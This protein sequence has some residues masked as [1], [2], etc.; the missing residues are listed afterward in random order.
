M[1]PLTWNVDLA[2]IAQTHADY[3]WDCITPE[4]AL[5]ELREVKLTYHNNAPTDVKTTHHLSFMR[6]QE[7][8]LTSALAALT[9]TAA[10]RPDAEK[11]AW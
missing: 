8:E 7:S 10:S 9:S 2:R 4:G 11:L 1:K 6:L 5:A 3:I